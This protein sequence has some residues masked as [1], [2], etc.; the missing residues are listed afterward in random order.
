MSMSSDIIFEDSRSQYY[1]LSN[2]FPLPFMLDGV[3]WR[4][5]EHYYQS[6]RVPGQGIEKATS[7][8]DAR[9]RGMGTDPSLIR[10]DWE[11]EDGTDVDTSYFPSPFTVGDDVMLRGIVA[12][13]RSN[14]S[15][16][17]RLIDTTPNKIIYLSEDQYWGFSLISKTGRNLL[18]IM[19]MYVRD[20]VLMRQLQRDDEY[21]IL[22]NNL[23]AILEGQGYTTI[24]HVDG[25]SVGNL[26]IKEGPRSDT[27]DMEMKGS[28]IEYQETTIMDE[29]VERVV[30]SDTGKAVELKAIVD[31]YL[32][33]DYSEDRMNTILERYK[34]EDKK[35]YYFVVAYLSKNNLSKLLRKAAF[36]N[37]RFFSPSELFVMP[38]RS[39]LSPPINRV[40]QGDPIYNIVRRLPE[41]SVHDKYIKEKGFEVGDV[42]Y[43]NDFS[44]HYR[45]VV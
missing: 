36:G 13:F 9:K 14:P 29:G 44:P 2:L 24:T 20:H 12:K 31:I 33:S 5:V 4:S 25:Q 45:I 8:L 11:N 37:A 17:Q 23:Y 15:Y 22:F 21:T 3:R 38:S 27:R 34:F 39:I 40:L 32:S 30:R 7:P 28:T 35:P 1:Y 26:P 19:L 42:I 43:V 10:P 41:I 16:L 18:G 6:M